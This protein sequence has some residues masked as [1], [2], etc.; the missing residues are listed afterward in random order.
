MSGYLVDVRPLIYLG[1]LLQLVA[2]AMFVA[3][4][5][6]SI[7]VLAQEALV[8]ICAGGIGL[9]LPATMLVIQAS[10]PTRDMAATSSGWV[11]IRS[12]GPSTGRCKAL[13]SSAK[14]SHCT[15]RC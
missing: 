1:Y 3:C 12:L 5:D 2:Y 8:G 9:A 13:S 15:T 14:A 6:S 11:L 7:N 4:F 10:V